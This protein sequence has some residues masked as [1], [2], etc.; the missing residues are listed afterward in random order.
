LF[1]LKLLINFI[2]NLAHCVLLVASFSTIYRMKGTLK[3][4]EDII[5]ALVQKCRICDSR[6]FFHFSF[7]FKLNNN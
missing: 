7:K 1:S 5:E 2:C 4:E 3:D 6:F